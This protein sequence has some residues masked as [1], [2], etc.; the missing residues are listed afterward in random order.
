M[1]L[2]CTIKI[3]CA[4]KYTKRDKMHLLLFKH[5]LI[6]S[7]Y[8]LNASSPHCDIPGI[9]NATLY[10][11]II[12][13]LHQKYHNIFHDYEMIHLISFNIFTSSYNG[14]TYELLTYD[15]FTKLS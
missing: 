7:K 12:K 13:N 10:F 2:V 5:K 8:K 1:D 11:E 15:I 4:F 9:Y 6:R 3:I 14:V